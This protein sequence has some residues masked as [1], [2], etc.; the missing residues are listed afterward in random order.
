MGTSNKVVDLLGRTP[1]P[2]L[3]ILEVHFANYDS[4]KDHYA[5]DKDFQEIWV[6]LHGPTV[7]NHTPFLDYTI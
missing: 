6:S 2:V 7:I 3:P 5:I 1:N 4:Q